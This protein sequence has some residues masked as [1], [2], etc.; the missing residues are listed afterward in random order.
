MITAFLTLLGIGGLGSIVAAAAYPPFGAALLDFLKP[1]GEFLSRVPWYAYAAVALV[2]LLLWLVISRGD[3]IDRAH[4]DEARLTAL[5]Q[6]TRDA[7]RNPKL[8]CGATEKQIQLLGQAVDTL[9]GSLAQQNAAVKALGDQTKAE[10]IAAEKASQAAQ[11]RA[12]EAQAV[13]DRLLASSHSAAGK[14]GPAATPGC[15]PSTTL[16]DQW[17]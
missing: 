4:A 3:W 5:C 8:D 9:K 10:Q 17:R 7:A 6:A 13:A 15:Q 14:S 11:E 12:D 2:G 16:Q 1:I